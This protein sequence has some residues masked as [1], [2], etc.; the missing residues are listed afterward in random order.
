M[1]RMDIE[2][3]DALSN[4][5]IAILRCLH[6]GCNAGE[7]ARTVMDVIKKHI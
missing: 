6:T 4:L 5:R 1:N 2:K 3:R 7:I